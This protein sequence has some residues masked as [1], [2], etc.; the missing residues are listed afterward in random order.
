M[1]LGVGGR[2][3]CAAVAVLG[4][5]AMAP[6]AFAGGPVRLAGPAHLTR[7]FGHAVRATR[8]FQLVGVHWRGSG[9]VRLQARRT[10]G[11]WTRWVALERTEPVWVGPARRVRLRRRGDVRGVRIAFV[12]SP[13]TASPRRGTVVPALAVRPR[14]VTRA[15]WHAD[16]SIRRAPPVYAAGL[17][18]VF[19]HHTDTATSAP[20]SE[21]ARIVRGIYA[22]HV[23]VNG[24]NDIGYNFLVDKC[25]TVFEGRYGGMTKPVIGAQTKGFNTGS[26]GIA[27]I[28]T[29]TSARP[30]H[31]A[32]AALEHLIAWRLDVAHVNP[33]ARVEMVS[34][35][36]P[37]YQRGRHVMFNAVSGH[38]DGY[39]TSCP[40]PAL[41]ALLPRIRSAAVSIGLPKIWAPRHEPNLHRIAPDAVLPLLMRAR[42]S[43]LTAFTL[44]I[45]G[46]GG[47]PVA[48]RR[49]T[50]RHIRWTW[51]GRAAVLPGGTYTW[52]ISAPGARGFEGV[53]GELPLWGLRAP[54]D[55]F[56]A[57]QG[58]V[59]SGNLA[60][61]AHPD[62]ST[63]DLAPAGGAPKTEL[64]ADFGIDTTRPV[65]LAGTLAGAGVATSA[66]GPVR[67]ELW[68]FGS[69]SWIDAG[70]CTGT[71][72]RS[73]KVRLAAAGRTFAS[74]DG[75]WSQA[76]IR[77]RY[78]FPG[79]AS[80]DAV[81]ALLN[82]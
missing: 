71:P 70:S 77:V 74:W 12:T 27:V 56:S 64:V 26:A 5:L 46:P 81:H 15:G 31:A 45:R 67:V 32:L 13:R 4:V 9:T 38:R 62:G 14:V 19:V 57:A 8:T 28:G 49:H 10:T 20:C 16:E 59:T 30:P 53:L 17:E 72:G 39:P 60:D 66:G 29:Y 52:T 73:C 44:T 11:T 63:V 47:H 22:Y 75:G 82:G 76:R 36:N 7:P 68:D 33:V 54:P 42:F 80:V 37:R 51:P 55:G 35:G 18:M 69:S 43:H 24:W 34:S 79:A 40:G 23:R 50:N 6:A 1:R 3:A 2:A 21:S 41:Y 61:L 65:A 58:T 48:R 25:G 78:T